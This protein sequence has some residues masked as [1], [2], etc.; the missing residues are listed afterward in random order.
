MHFLNIWTIKTTPQFR[1]I[2]QDRHNLCI[3]QFEK[4]RDRERQK[5]RDRDRE[6]MPI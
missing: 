1:S 3:E 4:D 5:Q 6:S 2:E